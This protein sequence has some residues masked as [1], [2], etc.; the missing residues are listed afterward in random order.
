MGT[1][2]YFLIKSL[3]LCL[4]LSRIFAKVFCSQGWLPNQQNIDRQFLPENLCG[5]PPKGLLYLS[6]ISVIIASSPQ[7]KTRSPSHP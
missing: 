3:G 2:F 4:K 6:L 5:L 7:T 1:A